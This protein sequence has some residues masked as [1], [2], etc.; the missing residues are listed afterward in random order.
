LSETKLGAG[1]EVVGVGAWSLELPKLGAWS[2]RSLELA[3]VGAGGL[4]LEPERDP[5][6]T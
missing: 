4:S 2:C 1:A 3:A 6:G 5:R